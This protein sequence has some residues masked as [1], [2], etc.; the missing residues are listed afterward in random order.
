MKAVINV[1]DFSPKRPTAQK[2]SRHLRA[3]DGNCRVVR[4]MG[5]CSDF[6]CFGDLST[7]GSECAVAGAQMDECSWNRKIQNTR[8]CHMALT[9]RTICKVTSRWRQSIS[10]QPC[11][12][13]RDAGA[14]NGGELRE[15]GHGAGLMGTNSS[16][17]QCWVP[18][19]PCSARLGDTAVA[20]KPSSNG[21][22]L[23][24]T[25]LS[26]QYIRGPQPQGHGP[27]PVW[28]C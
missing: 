2:G 25:S 5:V 26:V 10:S 8:S 1:S 17:S 12:Q 6:K 22:A 9:R 13:G 20:H 4:T 21:C 16:P 3:M 23:L 24:H 27:V 11:R 14:G 28:A 7:V 19:R 18:E 15:G